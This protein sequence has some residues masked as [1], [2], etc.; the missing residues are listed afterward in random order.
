MTSPIRYSQPPIELPV[1][2][3]LLDGKP[4]PGCKVCGALDLQRSQARERSDWAVACA[5]A[6][7]IRSHRREHEEAS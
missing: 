5:A 7:E 4:V 1:D 6:R 2:H 3:W